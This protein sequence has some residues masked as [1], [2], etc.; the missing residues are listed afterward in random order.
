M[1]LWPH[2][3]RTVATAVAIGALLG[4][5]AVATDEW[6]EIPYRKLHDAFTTIQPLEDAR[7]IRL[8]HTVGRADADLASEPVRLVIASASGDIE[9]RVEP[10]GT[11][12]FPLDFSL[13]E[14]DPPVRTNAPAGG[15]SIGMTIDIS[16]PPTERFPYALLVDIDEEYSRMVKK[17]GLMAR[18]LA[19]KSSGLELRFAAGE[20]A[21]ATIGG[22]NGEV[23]HADDEGRLRIPSRRKWRSE[24]PEVVLSHMPASISL[25]IGN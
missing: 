2:L 22:R 25:A 21:T 8:R 20:P 24:N 17:Q 23:F 12:D 5:V 15:L 18:M 11:V 13:L 3:P 9:V 10:D 19:P 6:R 14:E 1:N 4:G 7:Y 16:A